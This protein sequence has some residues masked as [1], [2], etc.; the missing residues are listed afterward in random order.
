MM[1]LSF[2]SFWMLLTGKLLFGLGFE[3]VWIGMRYLIAQW[4]AGG[5]LS[6]AANVS[7]AMS[8]EYVFL[9]GIVTPRLA[10]AYG[11]TTS[12]AFG[13]L[14]AAI[15]VI[16]MLPITH[17]HSR[18][19]AQRTV[20]RQDQSGEEQTSGLQA[21]WSTVR[22]SSTQTVNL[23]VFVF[24]F[25]ASTLP[26]NSFTSDMLQ[27]NY[28]LS[29]VEAGQRYGYI[30]FVSGL[31][32]LIVGL[33]CDSYGYLGVLQILGAACALAGNLFWMLFPTSCA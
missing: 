4:F 25:Y 1:A 6:F 31:V 23:V 30:Y 21:W 8:R 7:F 26:I 15:C 10:E 29:S 18:L 20:S 5:E 22:Q 28:G 9:C 13:L 24:F 33:F 17:Q 12:L 27:E 11:I 3:P 2:A 19:E 32:L 16:M 14:G